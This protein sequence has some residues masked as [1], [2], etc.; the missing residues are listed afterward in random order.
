LHTGNMPRQ[1]KA[2][3][4]SFP[5]Q[6]LVV[7][8]GAYTIKAGFASASPD[9]NTDCHI[10]PN[11]L[12]KSRDNRVYVGAQLEDCTDFGD[13][14]FRRPVQKGFLVNWEAEREIWDKSFFDKNAKVKVLRMYFYKSLQGR[15]ILFHQC[16]PHETNL[17]LTEAPSCPAALQTN[18][19]QMVFEEFEFA[20]YRRCVGSLQSRSS[21]IVYC[22]VSSD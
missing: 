3:E 7:D 15:L 5:Q 12:G 4:L 9:P 16:D 1:S 2:N 8:N 6:T 21:R 19:D 10:I 14:A 20:A 13:M 17:I 22:L 18:C 11:C